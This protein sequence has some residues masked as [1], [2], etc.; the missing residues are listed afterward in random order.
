MTKKRPIQQQ[1]IALLAAIILMLAITLILTNIFYRHQIDVS[2]ATMALHTDQA[3]LI[4]LSGE[5]WARELLEEDARNPQ[6]NQ[7]DHYGELWAQAMPLLPVEGGTLTGCI[8]DLQSRVNL[9]SFSIYNG[10]SLQAELNHVDN[11]GLAKTWLNLLDLLEIPA[12]PARAA[13]IIDWLDPNSTI[14]NSFGAEQPDYDGLQPLRVV[15]NDRISDATELADV[16]GYRVQEVQLLLPWLA[17]LPFS[18]LIN[19]NTASEELL[20]AMG[21]NYSTQFVDMVAEGRPFSDV[22]QFYSQ[23][24][25][26]L[27]LVNPSN[28]NA[29]ASKSSQIW[30]DLLSVNTEFF[31]LYL[32]VAIGE[33][34]IEVTSILQRRQ[35]VPT[36]VVSRTMVM[37][38]AVLPEPKELSEIERLFAKN[39]GQA[40]QSDEES[41]IVQP[42]CL[43]MGI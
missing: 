15:A 33:A 21:G 41:N 42:A 30:K 29:N 12:S 38:P 2:Q 9:N 1:G 14:V 19:I 39:E 13:T 5:S 36:T 26:Y 40:Q 27:G 35:G 7:S 11:M 37:V 23:L 10:P 8:S 31:Q 6:T 16:A 22:N 20:F 4:A 3:L 32:E 18:T 25:T 34:R 28:T 17:A 24:D 43:M